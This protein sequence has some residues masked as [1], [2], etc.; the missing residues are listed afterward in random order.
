MG[1]DCLLG[2]EFQFYKMQRVTRVGGGDSCTTMSMYLLPL[3]CTFKNGNELLFKIYK[4]LMEFYINTPQKK[5][6]KNEQKIYTDISP[7][8]DRRPKST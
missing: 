4:H 3:N 1:S 5:P 6:I 8:T 2:T 7:K